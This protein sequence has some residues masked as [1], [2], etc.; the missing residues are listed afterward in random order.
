M[1]PAMLLFQWPE[2][3]TSSFMFFSTEGQFHHQRNPKNDGWISRFSKFG[4]E[5]HFGKL[6][7]A[8]CGILV[9]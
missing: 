4:V 6:L 9:T 5:D 1:I 8:V 2:L 7:D 3:N